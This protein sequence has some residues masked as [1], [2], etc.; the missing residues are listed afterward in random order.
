MGILISRDQWIDAYV[1]ARLAAT[2]WPDD[3][4]NLCLRISEAINQAEAAWDALARIRHGR[5]A[6]LTAAKFGA[7]AALPSAIKTRAGDIAPGCRVRRMVGEG[8]DG[9]VVEPSPGRR[10]PPGVGP[11]VFLVVFDDSAYPVW[12]FAHELVAMEFDGPCTA[13]D[14]Y[15]DRPPGRPGSGAEPE[16]SGARGDAGPEAGGREGHVRIDDGGPP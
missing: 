5:A 15:A 1:A 10:T 4:Y 3:D 2:E 13:R 7:S 6:A 11:P 12:I 16:V 14:D 9:F 8:R